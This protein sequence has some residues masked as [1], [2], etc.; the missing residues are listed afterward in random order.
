MKG[1]RLAEGEAERERGA[2]E[3]PLSAAR[4]FLRSDTGLAR[5]V[6]RNRRGLGPRRKKKAWGGQSGVERN[7]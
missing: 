5:A 6:S 2:K 7:G 3:P 4:A 1:R